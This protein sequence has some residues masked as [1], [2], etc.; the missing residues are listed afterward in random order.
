M[1]ASYVVL[2]L[3]IMVILVPFFLVFITGK[4]EGAKILGDY[5]EILFITLM[6]GVSFLI[7]YSDSKIYR[8]RT[9]SS[10]W[11]CM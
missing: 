1:T 2:Q 8:S 5:K 7:P 10:H 9:S 3:A 4:H 11:I 6:S